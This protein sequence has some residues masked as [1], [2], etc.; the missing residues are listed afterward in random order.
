MSDLKTLERMKKKAET[1]QAEANRAQGA[2]EAGLKELKKHYDC[3]DLE[4]AEE[5]LAVLQ[6]K[7]A[8]AKKA[9]EKSVKEFEDKWGDD[10]F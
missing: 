9:F 1:L 7:E 8:A 10:D 3:D 2:V 6:D 5:L 4:E